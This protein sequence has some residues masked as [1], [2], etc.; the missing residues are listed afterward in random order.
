MEAL[1]Y[2]HIIWF[3]L[4][5]LG[6]SLLFSPNRVSCTRVQANGNKSPLNVTE[7]PLNIMDN[8]HGCNPRFAVR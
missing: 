3:P 7:R 8:I 1:N 5:L 6:K 2:L 4:K